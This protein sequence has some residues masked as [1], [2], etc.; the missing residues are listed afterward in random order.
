MVTA[1]PQKNKKMKAE[2][3]A[4]IWAVVFITAWI[5]QDFLEGAKG[6]EGV[7]TAAMVVSITSMVLLYIS[8]FRAI[9]KKFNNKK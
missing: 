8:V 5:I 6:F 1:S 3:K 9:N 7:R 4:M 2:T